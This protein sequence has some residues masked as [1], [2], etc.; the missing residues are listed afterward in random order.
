MRIE[1]DSCAVFL[2]L[3]AKNA[4]RGAQRK[5]RVFCLLSGIW[6]LYRYLG[7]AIICIVK[8]MATRSYLLRTFFGFCSVKLDKNVV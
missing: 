1:E 6:C 2:G 4:K 7:D 3:T 5:R 8:L